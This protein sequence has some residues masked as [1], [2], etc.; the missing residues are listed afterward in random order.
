M[1]LAQQL[2]VRSD[3]PLKHIAHTV[4]FGDDKSFIRAFKNWA[5]QTP[6]RF[7]DQRATDVAN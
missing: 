1:R 4:G 2:L 3:K 6:Q 5:G 7:R